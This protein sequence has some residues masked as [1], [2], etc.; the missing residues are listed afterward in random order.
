MGRRCIFEMGGHFAG[1]G[2][3]DCWGREVG[4]GWRGVGWKGSEERE[5]EER[6]ERGGILI[7]F[8]KRCRFRNVVNKVVKLCCKSSISPNTHP[9]SLFLSPT[10]S[11]F[12]ADGIYFLRRKVKDITPLCGSEPTSRD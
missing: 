1:I 6:R 8:S 2:E 9:L 10:R 11:T 7:F 4:E 3:E 12:S 5:E